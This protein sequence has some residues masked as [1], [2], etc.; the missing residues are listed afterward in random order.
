MGVKLGVA[1]LTM[2]TRPKELAELLASVEMQTVRPARTVVVAQG[3]PLP[4]LPAWVE[5]VELAENLGVTGGRNVALEHLRDVDV[6][7]DLDDDGLLVADDVFARIEALYEADPGLGIV[8]FRIADETGLTQRRHVPRLRAGDPMRGGEVTS[9]LGGGHGLSTKMLRQV[10][11]WPDAFFFAHEETDMAW[12]A[13]DADWRVLYAPELLLQHPRTSP[14]RHAFFYRVNARN[15]VY[16]ARRHLPALLVPVYLGVWVAL[17]VARTR[18]ATGL[19]AWFSGFAE[20]WR[21][22]C[23]RRKPMRW[24]TVWTMTRLGRPPII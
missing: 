10:G 6:V 21:T 12:R 9:F 8:S 15:R 2:G 23:G 11:D 13:L 4:E 17:T 1:V 7:I 22:P 24:R 20:G 18:N 19:K 3:C 16:L 14:T 5:G